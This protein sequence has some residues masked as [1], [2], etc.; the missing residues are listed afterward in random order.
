MERKMGL[1]SRALF[2]RLVAPR[3]PVHG[4]VGVLEQVGAFLV[5]EPVG[6]H[7]Y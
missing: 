1:S 4:I 6:R 7:V 3:V 5:R 2:E